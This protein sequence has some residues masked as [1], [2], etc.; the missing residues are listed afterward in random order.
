MRIPKYWAR[1]EGDTP[2]DYAGQR[3]ISAWG[4]S[5]ESHAE[6]QRHAQQRLTELLDRIRQGLGL[7]KGYAYGT[8]PLRE[9]ILEELRNRDGQLDAV[10]TRNSYGSVVLNAAEVMFV[11]VDVPWPTLGQR[12]ARLFGSAKPTP[13]AST[14]AR[15]R[16]TLQHDSGGSYRI[17]RTAAGFRILATDPLFAPG[18]PEAQTVMERLGADP[19]F[20]HLCKVQKSFRARLSPKP[21]RCGQPN[22]PSRFP[23]EDPRDQADFQA[24]LDAYEAATAE[25]ATCRFVESVG[26][27]RTHDDAA[28]IVRLH[29]ERT[30]ATSERPLA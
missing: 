16:E 27:G 12:L 10:L 2:P 26:W 11:D 24:W 23:R 30:N 1:A 6:A 19:S 14:L 13:E 3:R 15:I 28:R 22:P 7:P 29:D 25:K 18:S 21:W 9:E 8:R 20:L 4:W 5:E 17:Y